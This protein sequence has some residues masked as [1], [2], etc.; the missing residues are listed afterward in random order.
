MRA[1]IASLCLLTILVC[2]WLF[3]MYFVLR[4]P[5]YQERAALVAGLGAIAAATLVCTLL[6]RPPL[7]LR[8]SVAAGAVVLIYAGVTTI[9]A[10]HRAGHF[11][12]YAE[13]SGWLFVALGASAL[14]RSRSLLIART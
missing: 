1:V 2:G 3:M 13:I 5:G 12:G 14:L 10:N 6:K 4:H 11:E 9:S 8:A 7:W